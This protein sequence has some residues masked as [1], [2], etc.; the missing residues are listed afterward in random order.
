MEGARRKNARTLGSLSWQLTMKGKWVRVRRRESVF[1]TV[2]NVCKGLVT[3]HSLA[4]LRNCKKI[5]MASCVKGSGS[6]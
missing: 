3:G 4:V 6:G 2:G 5:R 1:H